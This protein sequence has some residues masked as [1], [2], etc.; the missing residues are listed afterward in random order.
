MPATQQKPFGQR[1]AEARNERGLSQRMLV[2]RIAAR[3]TIRPLK[4]RALQKLER[5][6][7]EHPSERTLRQLRAFFPDLSP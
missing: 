4:L 7:T 5:G 1:L 2:L 3:Y 6:N